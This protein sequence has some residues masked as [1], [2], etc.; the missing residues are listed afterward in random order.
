MCGIFAEY[1]EALATLLEQ[2]V[3]PISTRAPVVLAHS[4]GGHILLRALHDRPGAFSAAVITAPMIS[5]DMRG[6]PAWIVRLLSTAMCAIGRGDD[7]VWGVNARDPLT[8]LFENNPVTSDKARWNAC[9]DFL[10][11]HPALRVVGPTWSWMRAAGRSMSAMANPGYARR[12]QTPTL[13]FGAGID[14]I[15]LTPAT[16]AFASRMPNGK[17]IEIADARHEILMELDAIRAQFWKAFDSFVEP[18]M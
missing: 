13:I 16:R 14:R 3:A 11:A 17:Y 5:I 15:C 4:M 7:W 6:L 10:L 12:I 2:L 18:Y 9:H 8:D 1:D